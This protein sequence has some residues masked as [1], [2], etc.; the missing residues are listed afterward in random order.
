MHDLTKA[1]QDLK[2]RVDA[3]D[4]QIEHLKR[5]RTKRGRAKHGEAARY[6]AKSDE[7]LRQQNQRGTGPPRNEDGT[8][9]FDDLD[10]YQ[11]PA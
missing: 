5:Q 8:Y 10:L 9:N 2:R 1:F 6:L 4:E 3:Q 11:P 7:W